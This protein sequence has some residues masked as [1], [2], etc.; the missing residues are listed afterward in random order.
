MSSDNSSWSNAT[1]AS[2]VVFT[3]LAAVGGYLA[4]TASNTKEE[5]KEVPINQQTATS[6]NSVAE[7]SNTSASS[8]T[9]ASPPKVSKELLLS[10]YQAV[11]KD[12]SDLFEQMVVTHKLQRY[13][14]PGHHGPDGDSEDEIAALQDFF[15]QSITE[16]EHDRA[17]SLGWADHNIETAEAASL[18][19]AEDKDISNELDKVAALFNQLALPAEEFL[20]IP[21][22]YTLD[23]FITAKTEEMQGL[24]DLIA[25]IVASLKERYNLKSSEEFTNALIS[26]SPQYN[27]MKAELQHRMQEGQSTVA[28]DK[29]VEHS[30]KYGITMIER[31]VAMYKYKDEPLFIEAMEALHKKQALFL[32]EIG[33]PLPPGM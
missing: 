32:N 21:D 20:S 22:S 26:N 24:V 3:I 17:I 5:K 25:E 29:A 6:S 28:M 33:L 16:L 7:P 19:Y 4:L 30:A 10:V 15:S 27:A 13:L 11:N 2:V 8:D 9:A 18:F 1:I 31:Y 12:A 23:D 14:E